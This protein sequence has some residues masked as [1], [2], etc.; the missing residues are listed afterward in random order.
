MAKTLPVVSTLLFLLFALVVSSDAY[1]QSGAFTIDNITTSDV[2]DCLT[3]DGEVIIRINSSNSGVSPY[4]V[5]LDNG[6]TWVASNLTPDGSGDI[7]VTGQ[8]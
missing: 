7:T 5:S 2:S 6:A 3:A 1:G 8:F 4:D